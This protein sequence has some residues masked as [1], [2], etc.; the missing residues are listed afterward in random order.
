MAAGR[1][2]GG[3]GERGATLADVQLELPD[4]SLIALIGA[5]GAG[6]S[7]LA[8]RL[9]EPGRTLSSDA[10]RA[11]V[12]GDATDQGATRAAFAILHRELAKRMAAR[13][14]A[15]IDAT[16]VTS[17][18]RRGLVRRATAAGIPAVAIVLALPPALVLARNA[19]RA[20]R[21]V[22]EAAVRHQLD[23]LDRSLRRGLDVEGF[24]A[25]HVLRS[26][27]EVDDLQ[28]VWRASD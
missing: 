28:V 10:F 1:P 4:P 9:F 25:V 22:P 15:V 14:S 20:G 17:F 27:A 19:T 2:A 5:A 8:A 13:Q 6:K 12:S 18:A 3:S 26:A 7:T 16:N 23:D 24:V 21:I 11:V